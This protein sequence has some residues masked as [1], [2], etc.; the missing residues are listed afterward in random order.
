MTEF[1]TSKNNKIVSGFSQPGP[2]FAHGT[3]GAK[4]TV[5]GP[6]P[7]KNF[8]QNN[9]KLCNIVTATS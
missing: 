4:R 5:G 2:V 6:P 8:Q 3:T 1:K 7:Q 9:A